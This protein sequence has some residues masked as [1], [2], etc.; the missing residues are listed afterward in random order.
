MCGAKATSSSVIPCTLVASAGIGQVGS[1]K[2]SNNALPSQSM[3]AIATISASSSQPGGFG[4]EHYE[5]TA[6]IV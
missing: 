6:Q 3:M 4:V 2:V 5:V 1:T